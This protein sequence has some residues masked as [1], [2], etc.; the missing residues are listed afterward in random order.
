MGYKNIATEILEINELWEN[1]DKGTI[2]D[3]VE[4]FLFMKYPECAGK[5]NVKIWVLSNKQQSSS[6]Y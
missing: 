4:E 5:W 6:L 2:A 1:T 3:N